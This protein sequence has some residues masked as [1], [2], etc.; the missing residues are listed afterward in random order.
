MI[1]LAGPAALD[2]LR[3]KAIQLSR[4][5]LGQRPFDMEVQH[6][7]NP[8]H[9]ILTTIYFNHNLISAQQTQQKRRTTT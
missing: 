2:E 4:S 9:F 1:N 6:V 8:A 5:G 3:Q 7:D